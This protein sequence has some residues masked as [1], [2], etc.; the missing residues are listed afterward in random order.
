[1]P[2]IEDLLCR[3]ASVEQDGFER[4]F[5]AMT[6]QHPDR[7]VVHQVDAVRNAHCRIPETLSVGNEALPSVLR[8]GLGV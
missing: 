4:Q 6:C 1:M 8:N 5:D 7:C 2:E 3:L